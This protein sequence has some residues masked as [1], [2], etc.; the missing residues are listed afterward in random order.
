MILPSNS[1]LV[2]GMMVT[3]TIVAVSFFLYFG[4][5]TP[6]SDNLAAQITK[7]RT[8]GVPNFTLPVVPLKGGQA[9]QVQLYDV[10]SKLVLVNYW[11]SWCAPC[12]HEIPSLLKLAKLYEKELTILAISIEG[13]QNDLKNFLTPLNESIPNNFLVL[14]DPEGKIAR[15]YGTIKIPESYLIDSQ[16]KLLMK[17]VDAQDWIGQE[18]LNVLSR[19]TGAPSK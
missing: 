17:V 8:L 14:H 10:K 13:N 15:E 3:A 6:S 4:T 9:S 2:W 7:F 5:K 1:K 19:Y 18:F 11:A 16:H 12:I